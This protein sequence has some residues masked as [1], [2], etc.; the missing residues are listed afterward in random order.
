MNSL[1]N[2]ITVL[3]RICKSSALIKAFKNM[4]NDINIGVIDIIDLLRFLISLVAANY[5]HISGKLNNSVVIQVRT[6]KL[7]YDMT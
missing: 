7:T 5:S 4:F 3:W 6:S 1:K 2:I